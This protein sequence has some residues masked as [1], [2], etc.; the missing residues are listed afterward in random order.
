MDLLAFMAEQRIL[1]EI[2]L[3]SNAVI[4]GIEGD[5]HP[6]ELYRSSG[7]P[8]AL[9]TDDEGV[10]RIDLTH[11][12]LRATQ[13]YDL[14]YAY[15]KELSRNAL[16]YSFLPGEG[17]FIDIPKGEKVRACTRD[18][19]GRKLSES[20]EALLK[21]SEKAGMQWQLEERFRAFEAGFD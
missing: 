4:L 13:S 8:L 19:V 1:V 14:S 6:F 17:L 5:D 10:A 20:C 9:S 12:Y 2:N 7:V 18:R 11:E 15:L 21:S 3:T 16:A